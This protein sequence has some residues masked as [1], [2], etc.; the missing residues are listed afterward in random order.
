MIPTDIWS[1]GKVSI[2][3]F[4]FATWLVSFP[5]FLHFRHYSIA[6]FEIKYCLQIIETGFAA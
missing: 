6:L 1:V 4:E 3:M 5:D 2:A